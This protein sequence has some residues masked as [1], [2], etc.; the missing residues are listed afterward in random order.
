MT[1]NVSPIKLIGSMGLVYL[2]IHEWLIFMVNVAKYT[3]HGSYMGITVHVRLGVHPSLI[4]LT[5]QMSR[6]DGPNSRVTKLPDSG[7]VATATFGTKKGL[8]TNW[9]PK[10]PSSYLHK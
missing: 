10:K 2:P 8:G 3:R 7:G 1:C 9:A 4:P 5:L 6:R